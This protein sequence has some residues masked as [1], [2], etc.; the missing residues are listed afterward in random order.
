MPRAFDTVPSLVSTWDMSKRRP[1]K[2]AFVPG[3]H[4]PLPGSGKPAQPWLRRVFH[5]TYTRRGR[6]IAVRGWSVKLQH[7][8]QRRTF[9]LTASTRLGAAVEARAIQEKISSEGWEA[10]VRQ[11]SGPRGRAY[12]GAEAGYWKERLL[13]RNYPA[14][15]GG[16]H[17]PEFST[18]IEHAGTGR[19]FPLGTSDAAAA[20]ARGLAIYR[21]VIEEGWDAAEKSYPR[22]VT[23]A[24]HWAYDPLLWTYTTVHTQVEG[25]PQWGDED[26]ERAGGLARILLVEGDPGIRGALTQCINRY[27]GYCCVACPNASAAR[28]QHATREA[29][30]CLV[31]RELARSMGL[32]HSD[33]IGVLADGLPAV[34][35]GV[36]RDSEELFALTPG[37]A[38]AYLLKRTAPEH[39][40]EPVLEEVSRGRVAAETL[41]RSAQSYFQRL[42]QTGLAE[43]ACRKPAQLTPREQDV[44]NLMSRGYVDKEIALA[45]GISAWTVHEHVKRI[46]EKLQVHSRTEAVLAYL[47]K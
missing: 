12:P 22:E 28:R 21:K 38:S 9:S 14:P 30:L 33:Q 10:V 42:L 44:L 47:Q 1:S 13:L 46:F 16:G 39:I 2:A 15:A 4:R 29:A 41:L 27:E 18:Y 5:N 43:E 37:G 3:L 31:N 40:L 8:G 35:Y 45:L 23:V 19:Y 17:Q 26:P 24:F 32:P 34:S 25:S 36:H 7:R 6:R 11:Y 20:A